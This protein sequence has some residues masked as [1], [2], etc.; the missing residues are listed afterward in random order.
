[1]LDAVGDCVKGGELLSDKTKAQSG[2][3]AT[4]GPV[5]KRRA[6]SWRL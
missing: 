4:E 6:V 1:M 2:R 3:S 5:A